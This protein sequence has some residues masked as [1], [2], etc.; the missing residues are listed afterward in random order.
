MVADRQKRVELLAQQLWKAHGFPK[1]C[2]GEYYFQAGQEIAFAE[3]LSKVS[4]AAT[5]A[6]LREQNRSSA[7]SAKL[8]R[9]T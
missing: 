3:N 8:A 1:G 2:Y 4:T 7:V 5:L 9:S 6:R